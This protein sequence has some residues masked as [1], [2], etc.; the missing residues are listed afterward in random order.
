MDIF[1]HFFEFEMIRYVAAQMV[2]APL[3]TIGLILLVPTARKLPT[4]QKVLLVGLCA[5]LLSILF[6]RNTF[7]Y[8]FTFLLPPICV[9][10]APVISKLTER[11][12]QLG[13]LAMAVLGPIL[14]Y[15]K[16]TL[17]HPGTSA[18]DHR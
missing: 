2:F 10:I 11:Y 8:F 5:P 9:A 18:R 7:P 6:Y 4:R 3:V 13:I 15:G 14:L 16:R 17:W 12:G 1:L